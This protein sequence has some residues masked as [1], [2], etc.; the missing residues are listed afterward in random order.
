MFPPLTRGPGS[1]GFFDGSDDTIDVER[2]S[3]DFE[4]GFMASGECF[5]VLWVHAR[6]NHLASLHGRHAR[7]VFEQLPIFLVG[8]RDVVDDDLGVVLFQERVGVDD[9]IANLVGKRRHGH[10]TRGF[11]CPAHDIDDVR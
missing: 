7:N 1:R 4:Y 9:P 5:D 10:D 6:Q 3:H 2:F 11:E 8:R